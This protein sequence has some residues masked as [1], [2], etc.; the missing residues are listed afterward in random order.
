VGIP[1]NAQKRPDHFGVGLLPAFVPLPYS[2]QMAAN[3]MAVSLFYAQNQATK[4]FAMGGFPLFLERS[5]SIDPTKFLRFDPLPGGGT[6]SVVVEGSRQMIGGSPGTVVSVPPRTVP[7]APVPAAVV[8][9]ATPTKAIP[10]VEAIGELISQIVDEIA[11]EFKQDPFKFLMDYEKSKLSKQWEL[12]QADGASIKASIVSTA[13]A[14]ASDYAD[15]FNNTH[16]KRNILMRGID[17]AYPGGLIAA[18]GR[19]RALDAIGNAASSAA[20]AVSNA[21]NHR[22]QILKAAQEAVNK[23]IDQVGTAIKNLPEDI[24]KRY[25]GLKNLSLEDIKKALREW[26]DEL[27]SKLSE[28]CEALKA[29][30]DEVRANK[31]KGISYAKQLGELDGQVSYEVGKVAAGIAAGVALEV[32]TEGAATPVVVAIGAGLK[33]TKLARIVAKGGKYLDDIA[34]SMG[35][36]G[37]KLDDLLTRKK[38]P[39]PSKTDPPEIPAKPATPT[40]PTAPAGSATGPVST[41]LNC[42]IDC[43][44]KA[45]T[46]KPG[47]NPIN[48]IYGCKILFEERELDFDLPAPLPMP[49]QRFYASNNAVVGALGQGWGL[50]GTLRIERKRDSLDLID[51]QGRRIS[52]PRVSAGESAFLAA[53]ELWLSCVDN[54]RL[55]VRTKDHTRAIFAPL[56]LDETDRQGAQ[57]ELLVHVATLDRNSNLIRFTYAITSG[58]GREAELN[59]RLTIVTDSAGRRIGLAYTQIDTAK[60]DLPTGARDEGLR[61]THVGQLLGEPD[62]NG[63]WPADRV[64]ALVSYAYSSEGDLV[65]VRNKLGEVVREFKYRN[66]ILVEHSQPQGE[67]FRYHY[68]QLNAQGRVLRAESSDG[69]W[70][71]L[72]YGVDEEGGGE[73]TITDSL[74]RTER[75]LYDKDKHWIG[76]IDSLGGVLQRKLGRHG[77]V[78]AIIDPEGRRNGYVYDDRNNVIVTTDATGATTHVTYHPHHNEPT[79][80][81]DALG[82]TTTFEHDSLGNLVAVTDANGAVTRFGLNKNGLVTA[83]TDAH[84]RVKTLEYNAA[85]QLTRYVDCS[86]EVTQYDYDVIGNL[87]RITDALGQSTHY[88]YD[89]R[90]RPIAVTHPD[91]ATERFEYDALNR[92]VANTDPEGTR[93][94]YSLA[95]DGLPISRKNALG[96]TLEYRY[97]HARRLETLVNENAAEYH[98]QYDPLDRLVAEQ[99]F[100]GRLTRYRYDKTGLPTAKME[101]GTCAID[102]LHEQLANPHQNPSVI[103]TTPLQ[104][105]PATFDDPWG[106]HEGNGTSS[107]GKAVYAIH[108]IYE[109]DLAGRLETKRVSRNGET[110]RTKY[111]YD[112]IGRLTSAAASDGNVVQLA[113]D[114]LGQLIEETSNTRGV[115]RSLRHA[116]DALGNRTQTR[117]PTGEALNHLYY[118]SGHLHQINI[119]GEVISDI[120]RDHLHRE[121][122]RTQGL[123]TSR[124]G[125]DPVGR[126]QAQARYLRSGGLA[127]QPKDKASLPAQKGAWQAL[128]D[129]PGST[130]LSSAA[131]PIGSL[132]QARRYHYDRTGNLIKTD[133]SRGGAT[134]YG[135]DA[136]GR[137]TRSQSAGNRANGITSRTELFAFDPAHNLLDV[138]TAPNVTSAANEALQNPG[139]SAPSPVAKTL[140]FIKNNRLEVFEDRRYKYDTHGN[141][142]EKRVG[143]HIII[144]LEWDVEH[145]LCQSTVTRNANASE[146]SA[147]VVQTTRYQYD[148][149]GRRIAKQDR[150]GHTHFVWDGNRLLSEQRGARHITYL[151]EPGSFAPLAQLVHGAA[152]MVPTNVENAQASEGDEPLLTIRH[153]RQAAMA[154]LIMAQKKARLDRAIKLAANDSERTIV[155]TPLDGKLLAKQLDE[156]AIAKEQPNSKKPSGPRTFRIRYYQ[157]DQIGTPRELTDESGNVRWAA[158]YKTWGNVETEFVDDVQIEGSALRKV[159]REP[160]PSADALHQPLRFQGQYFDEE[161]GLHYNQF[162]YYDPDCGRFVSQDPIGLFGGNHAY[163]YAPNPSRWVDPLGLTKLPGGC[164]CCMDAFKGKTGIYHIEAGGKMYTGQAA[165]LTKRMTDSG[166]KSLRALLAD[167]TAKVTLYEVNLGSTAAGG[168]T[169]RALR[170]FEQTVM[171]RRGNVA[172]AANS[173]NIPRA[174]GVERMD[175]FKQLASKNGAKWKRIHKLC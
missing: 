12:L 67:A 60:R 164:K 118:G 25:E 15:W 106:E 159:V 131:E 135:Y 76:K 48:P 99:G 169:T 28:D 13:K 89:Q 92:L 35:S 37:R 41:L 139:A 53:E 146:K 2:P 108:S 125:Y 72:H 141:I 52:F 43:A 145:Q 123:L 102:T 122:Q 73:T 51:D 150:F 87:L 160:T 8:T 138:P 127:A 75:F 112:T 115:L 152:G 116:Y 173:L 172:G 46:P 143:K 126:L 6:Q 5:F 29:A 34:K 174:A 30:L 71:M 130:Q 65:A 55:E 56:G 36:L 104:R 175:E 32:V 128:G 162:R 63:V 44:T 42:L 134:H 171:D 163:L 70:A 96:H 54:G 110:K 165:D 111:G 83:I 103:P 64:R 133:D 40:G 137:I 24:A 82:N 158:T 38:K 101:L 16:S 114:A 153:A 148:A 142:V 149:F 161:T 124:Y 58:A 21:W 31:A 113:Y 17:Y 59:P 10:C 168:D 68:D 166:H 121:T 156:P 27:V 154:P 147:Q 105:G 144:Q 100:D 62:A 95:P 91:G 88:R 47:K 77:V 79:S 151:Y 49:W 26:L 1:I 167:P 74:G 20:G 57:S 39:K 84:G 22:E 61:L 81:A 140:G 132:Q 129:L 33:A 11:D 78:L 107:Q 93:T 94:E 157:N 85:G 80:I 117:F 14:A 109:R 7:P 98:F 3:P 136:I 4:D 18:Y 69:Q 97:D 86:G 50:P 45:V 119:D 155:Q 90:D 120:E 9:D 170:Y 23:K 66:H 19:D